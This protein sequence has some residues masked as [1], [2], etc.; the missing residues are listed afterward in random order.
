MKLDITRAWKDELY[1]LNL[2]EEELLTLPESP[3]G[4]LELSDDILDTVYGGWGRRRREHRREH[5]R[6]H[7]REHHEHHEHHEHD[8]SWSSDS[9][10]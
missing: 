7:R 3:V 10:D 6:E 4:G 9:D 1:R 2:N 5:H 8:N